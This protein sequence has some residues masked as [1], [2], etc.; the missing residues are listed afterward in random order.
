VVF[1]PVDVEQSDTPVECFDD[2]IDDRRRR[3]DSAGLACAL[4]AGISCRWHGVGCE[5]AGISLAR[6]MA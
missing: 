6:G 3:A 5:G 4:E 1:R 2:H